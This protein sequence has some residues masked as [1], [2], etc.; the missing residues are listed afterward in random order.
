LY[1]NYIIVF[2]EFYKFSVFLAQLRFNCWLYILWMWRQCL[3]S[4][5]A[6]VWLFIQ[7]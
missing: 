7:R 6:S 4:R 1:C 5:F 2:Q 3:S